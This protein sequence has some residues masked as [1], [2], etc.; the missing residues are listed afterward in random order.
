[1]N[2]KETTMR[3]MVLA[4]LAA[5]LVP[6][7]VTAAPAQRALSGNLVANPGAEAGP[8]T[9]DSAQAPLPV[10]AW[11]VTGGFH[12]VAYA[13]YRWAPEPKDKTKGS[14]A[15][16][17]VGCFA[18]PGQTVNRGTAT[19]TVSVKRWAKAIA[20]GALLRFSAELGGYDGTE[21][22]ATA[23]AA[24]LDASGKRIGPSVG[25]KGPTYLQRQGVTRVEPRTKTARIPIGAASLRITLTGSRTGSGPCGFVDNVSAVL[26]AAP[27][28]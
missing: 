12:A 6:V 23:S 1:M 5:L 26:V 13:A 22:L 28:K 11:T 7:A 27:A 14:G 3:T 15:K 2:D 19:Q 25:L 21:N 16:F 24:F 18:E 17:F 20:K 10:P 4:A 9:P 8:A